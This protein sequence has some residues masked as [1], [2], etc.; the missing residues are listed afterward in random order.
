MDSCKLS[1][2]QNQAGFVASFPGLLKRPG[3]E[4]TGFVHEESM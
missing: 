2:V 4:A 1:Q 3:N